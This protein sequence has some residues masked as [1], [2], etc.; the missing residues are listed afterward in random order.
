MKYAILRVKGETMTMATLGPRGQVTIPRTVRKQLHLQGGD[1][2]LVDVTSEGT[3]VLRPAGVYPV[4]IY[5]DERIKE[6]EKEN[7][8]TPRERRKFA[9]YL[10][11][12]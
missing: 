6:F 7:R 9:R 3:I 8:M 11:G 5:S 4:E 1:P 12:R 2:L 10:R